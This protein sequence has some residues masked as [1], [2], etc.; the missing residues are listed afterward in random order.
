LRVITQDVTICDFMKKEI[1]A[2]GTCVIAS[3][4]LFRE[5]SHYMY[6]VSKEERLKRENSEYRAKYNPTL[7]VQPVTRGRASTHGVLRSA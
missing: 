1:Q 3:A 5:E 4:L 2:Q 6:I 7:Y